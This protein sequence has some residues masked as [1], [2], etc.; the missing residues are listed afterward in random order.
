MTAWMDA[1]G[2]GMGADHYEPY[3]DLADR[4]ELDMRVFWQTVR[5]PGTPGADGQ[6]RRG[7]PATEAVPGHRLFRQRRVRGIGLRADRHAAPPRQQATRSRKTW[8]SC[9]RLAQ[10]LAQRGH[11]FEH[12]RGD[13]GGDRRVS[14]ASI[15][16]INK[17]RPIKGLRWA[18]SHLDQITDEQ[19]E[20]MKRLGMT[21]QIHTPAA[22][23]GR[24]HARVHGDKAWDMPPFRRI[25]DSGITGGSAPT[26]PR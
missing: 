15:E 20:R 10:A 25:Q 4:G 3:R 2:R 1:G 21:A 5:Q 6:G 13:G 19:I 22:D 7:H 16:D 9:G 11:L 23:P 12:A 17:T 8:R 24:P 26:R 18:F 14:R